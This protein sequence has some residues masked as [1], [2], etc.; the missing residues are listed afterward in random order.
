[1]EIELRVLNWGQSDLDELAELVWESRLA[2]PLWVD[3]Q[4]VKVFKNYIEQRKDRFWKN[5]S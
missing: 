3:G 2:S 5:A 4:S 1:M